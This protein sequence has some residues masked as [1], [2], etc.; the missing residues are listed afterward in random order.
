[1]VRVAVVRAVEETAA[2]EEKG[3]SFAAASLLGEVS[4]GAVEAPLRGF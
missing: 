4:E 2:A 3:N 1:V